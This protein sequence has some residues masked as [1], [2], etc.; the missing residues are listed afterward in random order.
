MKRKQEKHLR[1][2]INKEKLLEIAKKNAG[3]IL[4][5]GGDF[6]G[7]DQDRLI[8]MKS[9]GSN[10]DEL[11]KFCKELATISE[12]TTADEDM[13]KAFRKMKG[14]GYEGRKALRNTADA[15]H[16]LVLKNTK[17]CTGVR[18]LVPSA[19]TWWVTSW[20]TISELT[21]TLGWQT[22]KYSGTATAT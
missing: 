18:S 12:A 11:T 6:M 21:T 1:S 3:K 19:T 16:L 5:A 2:K 8:S 9:G 13:I 20:A 4:K 10:L 15:A 17:H 7:M 14:G 22:T